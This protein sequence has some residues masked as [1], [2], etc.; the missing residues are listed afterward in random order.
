MYQSKERSQ[1]SET[2]FHYLVLETISYV[3]NKQD[4]ELK[5]KLIVNIFN[6]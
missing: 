6:K 5:Q 2:V 3:L 1:I 4:I